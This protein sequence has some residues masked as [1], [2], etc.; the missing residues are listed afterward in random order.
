MLL[1]KNWGGGITYAVLTSAEGTNFGKKIYHHYHRYFYQSQS[2]VALLALI[3]CQ[4]SSHLSKSSYAEVSPLYYYY[5]CQ[6]L[7]PPSHLSAT[8]VFFVKVGHPCPHLS[9]SLWLSTYFCWSLVLPR[10]FP[11]LRKSWRP[12]LWGMQTI[13]WGTLF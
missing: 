13:G 1:C 6:K 5:F 12:I 9:P 7:V 10:L 2:I 11:H 3:F 8:L 4:N